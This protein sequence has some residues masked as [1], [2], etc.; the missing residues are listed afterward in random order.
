MTP[1]RIRDLMEVRVRRLSNTYDA[2]DQVKALSEI[3]DIAALALEARANIDPCKYTDDLIE[4]DTK[5][6]SEG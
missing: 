2:H 4:P 3:H 6:S 1:S 5:G